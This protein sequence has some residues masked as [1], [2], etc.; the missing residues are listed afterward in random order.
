MA[1]PRAKPSK[2]RKIMAS[3]LQ[4]EEIN[5]MFRLCLDDE[6][7]LTT[8]GDEVAHA[9]RAFIKHII[10]EF[11]I[12]GTLH[13]LE[14][15]VVEPRFF[16]SYALFGIQKAYVEYRKDDLSIDLGVATLERRSRRGI[17]GAGLVRCEIPSSDQNPLTDRWLG[18]GR[19]LRPFAQSTACRIVPCDL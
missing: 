13:V 8:N 19:E 12:Q 4:V 5:G 14:R 9:S 2:T 15:K 10:A 7:L 1:R 3:D 6:I 11:D 17:G 16:G 18:V